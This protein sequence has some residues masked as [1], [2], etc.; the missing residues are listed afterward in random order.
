MSNKKYYYVYIT[1]NLTNGK[2]YIGSH[3]ANNIDNQYLGS[4]TELQKAIKTDGKENFSKKIIGIYNTREEAYVA[5]SKLFNGKWFSES[6]NVLKT[7]IG[8]IT[9]TEETKELLSKQHAGS[10]NPM[11]GKIGP[12]NGI[13]LTTDVKVK[14]SKAR[15]FSS[16]KPRKV[17]HKTLG[18]I[19]NS[20][21][22]AA[23]AFEIKYTVLKNQLLRHSKCCEF[24]YLK[25][26]D[27]D[28]NSLSFN[29]Q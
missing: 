21:R 13:K 15:Q 12:R 11:F 28:E 5:E 9:H 2:V 1:T 27:N 7:T 26:I 29:V 8:L 10:Q 6:Y 3:G 17:K 14:I 19:Y 4:G 18:T 22:K 25:E 20:I 16:T 24:E 23:E